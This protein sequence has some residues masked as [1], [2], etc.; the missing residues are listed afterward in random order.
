[1]YCVLAVKLHEHCKHK[2]KSV[3]VF[4][5]CV[6]YCC[7]YWLQRSTLTGADALKKLDG[8]TAYAFLFF[9]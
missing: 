7:I 8:E 4:K 1:M 2:Y 5:S 9:K 3:R 6:I